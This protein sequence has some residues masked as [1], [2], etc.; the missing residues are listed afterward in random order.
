MTK[1]LLTAII[2]LS[3]LAV[4]SLYMSPRAAAA[5]AAPDFTTESLRAKFEFL[6][7]NGNSSCSAAFLRSISSLRDEARLQGS[8]CSPMSLHRYVEQIK[9]LRAFKSA[10]GQSVA[11]IPDDPYDIEAGLAK[12]LLSY[13]RIAL[14]PEEQKHYQYASRNSKEKGPCCCRCWRWQVYGGLGKYLIRSHG[15]T[16]EQLAQVWDFSDGCGGEADHVHHG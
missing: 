11:L 3:A 6:S 7:K 13:Y 14:T 8:C 15:F 4:G 5:E 12:K 2:L 1:R 9:A 10:A 16:G